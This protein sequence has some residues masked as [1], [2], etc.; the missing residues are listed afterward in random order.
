VGRH[1]VGSVRKSYYVGHCALSDVR[2]YLIYFYKIMYSYDYLQEQ[3]KHSSS[4]GTVC[5]SS[6]NWVY[7]H[8]AI[9]NIINTN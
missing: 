2:D 7:R 4:P 3:G 6:S 9:D 8:L 5:G 1:L